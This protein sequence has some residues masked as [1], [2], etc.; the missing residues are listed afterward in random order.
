V[1]LAERRDG[2]LTRFR[3]RSRRTCSR[4]RF[5]GLSMSREAAGGGCRR[6]AWERRGN[7]SISC[8][9]TLN[10]LALSS[11]GPSGPR[12]VFCLC[13]L[14]TRNLSHTSAPITIHHPHQIYNTTII[15]NPQIT[16][17]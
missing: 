17:Q 6:A 3:A 8:S 2:E 4:S 9:I 7:L 10:P 1:P 14:T 16:N 11:L 5:V 13:V 12:V 15:T